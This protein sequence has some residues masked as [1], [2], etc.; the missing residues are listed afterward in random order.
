MV[1]SALV[2]VFL[3]ASHPAWPASSGTKPILNDVRLLNLMPSFWKFWSAAKGRAPAQQLQTWQ[4]LYVQQNERVFRDLDAPCARHFTSISL[5]NDYF[6]G[7][8]GLVPEMHKLERSLPRTI[9][10]T[11]LRFQQAFPDMA[12][13]GDIYMMASADCF[14]GRSQIIDGRQAL[15]LGLDDIAG[16]HETN[17]PVLLEH[18]LFH[19]YHHNFFAYEAER[20]EPMWVRLWAE[21]MATYVSRSLSP[22]A[23]NQEALWMTD[24]KVAHLEADLSQ[25]AASFLH[26]FNSTSKEDANDY[27]LLDVSND[28]RIPGHTGYY[29]GM[30]VAELLNQHYSLKTMA[31]WSRAEAEPHIHET[32]EQMAGTLSPSDAR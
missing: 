8:P 21:G 30:R 29:L 25:F 11:R 20:D 16:L 7:L 24:E 18:E 32:L 31:H 23:S 15:L 28:P 5:G 22:S 13:S 4:S 9:D 3:I 19:R 1:R 27:F 6:P 14:N 17:L 10:Q 12:W 26:G 2:L